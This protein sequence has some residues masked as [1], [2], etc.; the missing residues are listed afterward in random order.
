MPLTLADI[1]NL[2]DPR[3]AGAAPIKRRAS[4]LS[5]PNWSRRVFV[6]TTGATLAGLGL[7]AL[8]LLPPARQAVAGT[9]DINPNCL[10]INASNDCF[11]GCGPST[12]CFDCCGS[13]GWH[14]S[15][16]NYRLRSDNCPKGTGYDGWLWRFNANCNCCRSFI[17]FRC[18][19]GYKWTGSGW[20]TTICRWTVGCGFNGC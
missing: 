12:L 7:A 2:A 10:P 5:G 14:R 13:D 11:P 1:P 16:G 6:R 17:V 4:A 3:P 9:R 8:G 18:H 20:V 15:T 19:D